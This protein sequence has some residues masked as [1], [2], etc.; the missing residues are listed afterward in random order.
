M[1]EIVVDNDRCNG[2]GDC[3]KACKNRV[4]GMVDGKCT[5]ID[6]SRCK[7]CMLCIAYC[8]A[9]AISVLT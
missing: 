6:S 7:L 3:I 9:K 2:C 4:L 1:I 5:V 8:P